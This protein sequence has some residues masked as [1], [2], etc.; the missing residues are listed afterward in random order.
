MKLNHVDLTGRAR[1]GKVQVG[2][3]RQSG[4]VSGQWAKQG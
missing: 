3:A 2:W 1:H 4:Q